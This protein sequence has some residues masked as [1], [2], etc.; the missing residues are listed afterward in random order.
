MKR[1][2]LIF[3]TALTLLCAMGSNAQQALELKQ[4]S[5]SSLGIGSASFSGITPLG[6]NRYAVVSDD[7]PSDGF[8]LMD[9]GQDPT[10]GQISY[11]NLVGFYQN[12]S[13]K[14]DSRG[15]TVRDC[16]GIV[17][18]KSSR[19]VFISGEGDQEI[20]EYSMEGHP[21]GRKLIVPTIFALRNIVPNYGFEALGYDSHT[22]LFWTTSE[23]TLLADGP[24][25]SPEHP[26]AQNLLRLQAFGEDFLP[27]AEYAYRMDR[28]KRDDFGKTYVYGVPEITAL[29][30]GKLLV[31]EREANV[32]NGYLSSSVRCKLFLVDPTTG[33][34][35]DSAT[36]L[37]KLDPNRFLIKTL[38]ADFTTKLTPFNLS[39]ANFEGM[40]LGRKLSDGRQTVILISDSQN[41]YGVGPV[42]LKDYIKV[43]V[44]PDEVM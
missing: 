34:Q 17:Y 13:P 12:P 37:K 1:L 4:Q 31:L 23:S 3:A 43:L 28:G 20:L 38:L 18:H 5:L 14:T 41:G 9:I 19:T 16:E 22:G 35:I 42:R 40:C 8:F 15:M 32:S 21:T 2:K 29:P 33:W 25:A 7:E 10:T 6:N 11:A 30:N 44:L 39:F 24:C 36:D 26:D 27:K